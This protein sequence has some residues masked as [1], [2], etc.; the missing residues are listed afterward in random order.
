V[1]A[2]LERR[3][4]DFSHVASTS[5]KPTP[6][7]KLLL[8]YFDYHA[9]ALNNFV[10]QQLMNLETASE[11]FEKL[12]AQL[13]PACPL[14]WNKQ[15][16]DKRTQAYFTGIINMLIE[17]NAQGFPCDYDPRQL[18]TVTRDGQR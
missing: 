12:Y 13:R 1:L 18:T 16:G 10:Q 6:F 3:K 11:A 17:A 9:N 5:E 7:G 4:L 8:Q 15:K 2:A 14:P